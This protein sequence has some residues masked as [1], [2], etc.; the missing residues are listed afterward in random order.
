MAQLPTS[1]ATV[2][3][4]H[5]DEADLQKVLAE[6]RP[7]GDF[8]ESDTTVFYR[9]LGRIIGQWSADD[10]RL[11]IAPLLKTFSVMGRE[12]NKSAK[13]LSGHETGLR[14][15]QDIEIVSQLAMILALDP[16]VGSRPQAD[17]LINRFGVTP[18]SWLTPVSWP[19][20]T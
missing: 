20:T 4:P 17:E 6:L 2:A 19:P 9:Q 16:G 10:N 18:P 12:L 15:I 13:V 7:E 11:D 14:E 1:G 8:G 5:R 3:T